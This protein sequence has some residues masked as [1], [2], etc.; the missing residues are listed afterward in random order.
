MKKLYF[1][2]VMILTALSMQAADINPISNAFKNGDATPI[3]ANM[4][5]EV[6]MAVPGT[7]KK[8]NGSEAVAILNRFFETNKPSG[9]TVAHHADKNESG[10]IV[11]KL[12]TNTKEFR[13]NITY[14]VI[15]NKVIIQS[16][17]I[18]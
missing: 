18:E 6:D 3:A 15:D 8:G 7:T 13:V 14:T 12:P 11:G 4:D 9:F 17:R 5:A 2:F 16:I 10:F 1:I